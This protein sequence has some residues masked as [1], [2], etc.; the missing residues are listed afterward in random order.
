MVPSLPPRFINY[1][2][3]PLPDG[4]NT[5]IPVDSAGHKCD[6][7]NPANW[8]TYEQ[9][10]ATGLPVGWVLNG[11][12]Y[13]FVDID[14]CNEG[15]RWSQLALDTLGKFPGAAVEV[16]S[17]DNGLHVIGR[18]DPSYDWTKHRNKF[19]DGHL[20]FYTSGRF[21]A[22]GGA[23][24]RGGWQ[25]SAEI[26]H[27]RALAAWVPIRPVV[28]PA[29]A[30]GSISG[31]TDERVLECLL[32]A[33]SA[34]GVFGDAATPAQLWEGNPAVLARF[35][36]PFRPGQD[37]DH[38]SADSALL[39]HLAYW[40][41]RD[42]GQM[43][44][45]FR[46]SGLMRDKWDNRPDY[47]AA[48]I[49]GAC[50]ITTRVVDWTPVAVPT[51]QGAGGSTPPAGTI[52]SPT[53]QAA[54][55]E[56]CVYVAV[57][58]AVWTPR[59]GLL[60]PE[61]FRALYGGKEF[62]M[63]S[64]NRKFSRNA[65]E[66]LTESR[67]VTFPKV[68]TTTFRPDLPS[69]EIVDDTVNV[70]VPRGVVA[71][72][73]NVAPFFDHL[74]R[75]LPNATDRAILLQWI[76][77]VVRRPGMLIRWAPVLQ[78][79]YGNGKTLIGAIVGNML[80]T[81]YVSTPRP[82]Q[83][84]ADHNGFLFRKLLLLVDEPDARERREFMDQL[85]VIVT[86]DTIDIREMRRDGRSERNTVNVMCFTNYQGGITKDRDDRRYAVFH[87][88]QQTVED[89]QRDGMDTTYFNRLTAWMN[90]DGPAALRHY[91][92]SVDISSLPSR[93]PAT[94]STADAIGASMS[95]AA[96]VVLEMV[97]SEAIGF[98]GGF[99]SSWAVRNALDAQRMKVTRRS[100]PK[101]MHELGYSWA[102][103]APHNL[104]EEG[105]IRP[106]IYSIGGAGNFAGYLSA[107]YPARMLNSV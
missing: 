89:V 40:C 75:L 50:G 102:F 39:T 43:D 82:Q 101:I 95:E 52:L 84:N 96:L 74:A 103:K 99:V 58:H 54:W 47:R 105:G 92:E 80:G 81:E 3:E 23:G 45:L 28:E 86:N 44:R 100:F 65:F 41:Q 30:G 56:G 42:H 53:D 5:K 31:A 9:A 107:N 77:S 2:L 29:A 8:R 21:V 61:A 106:Q 34:A 71:A 22:F 49:G 60:K 25:G 38:S 33:R 26:D 32:R 69:G 11:D 55:F 94:T 104:F 70:F 51:G 36:P 66:C 13:F 48:S 85:K 7:H 19:G 88:A 57:D 24:G 90:G 59:Y 15:G 68:L 4:T 6:A 93:A 76:A 20:E 63:D 14:K 64:D 72:A 98:R 16:S 37:F 91:L 12:G 27:T 73:G 46:R 97:D 10:V 67:A 35:Y 87:T 1:R 18:C 78:G 83:L 62:A 17:S 79:T